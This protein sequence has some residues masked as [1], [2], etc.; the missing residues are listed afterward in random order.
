M[1]TWLVMTDAQRSAAVTLGASPQKITSGT[2]T[3]LWACPIEILDDP[4]YAEWAQG[5]S[6]LPLHTMSPTALFS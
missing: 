4:K 2:N 5:L 1:A 6:F 3:G